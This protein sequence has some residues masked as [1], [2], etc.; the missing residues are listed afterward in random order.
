MRGWQSATAERVLDASRSTLEA[1]GC[2]R[3]KPGPYGEW[4]VVEGN[5][6]ALDGCVR[7]RASIG[8]SSM[9]RTLACGSLATRVAW[10]HLRT[11]ESASRSACE[12]RKSRVRDVCRSAGAY[13]PGR[14]NVRQSVSG[15]PGGGLWT[16]GTRGQLREP[17]ASE[18]L[19]PHPSRTEIRAVRCARNVP[20]RQHCGQA[21]TCG[22]CTHARHGVW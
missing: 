10:W 2:L 13:E 14:E 21:R 17:A 12:S 9:S 11:A 8:L 1:A 5:R 19:V 3:S 18:D 20:R 16:D 6:L 7:G 15:S 22:W 4:N